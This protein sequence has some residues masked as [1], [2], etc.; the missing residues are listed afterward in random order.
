MG[1]FSWL[2]AKADA[3]INR[4]VADALAD[5]PAAEAT[6]PVEATHRKQS[7]PSKPG[8]KEARQAFG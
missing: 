5:P 1:L 2:D 3:Y 6:H 8:N 7:N 4:A